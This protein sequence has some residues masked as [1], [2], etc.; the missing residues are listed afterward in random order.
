MELCLYC[1]E[2]TM[3]PTNL[4]LAANR[5]VLTRRAPNDFRLPPDQ[6]L[7]GVHRADAEPAKLEQLPP[8]PRRG[9]SVSHRCAIPG[10]TEYEIGRGLE[11]KEPPEHELPSRLALQVGPPSARRR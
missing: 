8:I 3:A 7:P 11:P 9:D 1:A 5:H 10:G 6:R 4:H 2:P